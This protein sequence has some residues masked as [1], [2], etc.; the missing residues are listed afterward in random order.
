MS[1]PVMLRSRF[2][3]ALAAMGAFAVLL[4]LFLAPAAPAHAVG[5]AKLLVSI[6]FVDP[7]TGN[8]ITATSPGQY[9]D[10]VALR[11]DFSCLTENCSGATA[12]IDPLPLDPIHGASNSRLW[13]SSRLHPA[14]DGRH[15][16]W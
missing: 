10:R 11:V 7:A 15:D 5:D 8:P 13:N 16:Q 3:R 12:K 6:T 14:G 1:A 4:A 9:G 2:T